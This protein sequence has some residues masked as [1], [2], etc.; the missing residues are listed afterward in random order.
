MRVVR[1]GCSPQGELCHPE[2]SAAESK[3]LGEAG[4]TK[5]SAVNLINV[6][7]REHYIDT[8]QI[9]PRCRTLRE[10]LRLRCAPLRMTAFFSYWMI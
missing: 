6:N 5:K 2:R 4:S 10:V 7:P 9:Y 8:V 3:D 1:S